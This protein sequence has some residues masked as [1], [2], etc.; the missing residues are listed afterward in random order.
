[1][2]RIESSTLAVDV[3][4]AVGGKIGQIRDKLSGREFLVAP[5][6]PYRT[7]PHGGDWLQYDTSGMDDC[8]PNIAAGPYPSEPWAATRLP[9][10]GEW[11][12]G[13][14]NVI[15]ADDN[16]IVLERMGVDLPYF[17]RKTIRFA[18]DRTLEFSYHV[19]NRG[20][21]P[22]RYMW[23]AHPLISVEGRYELKLPPGDLTFRTFPS[24]GKHHAWPQGEGGDLSH[25]WISRGKDLK[26][27]I[28]GLTAGWCE[29]RLPEHTL[30]FT[31]DV[32]MTPVVGVWFN[33][34]GFPAEGAG[35]FRC[36]AVEPCTS[37]SD[38]LDELPASA[39]PCIPAGGCASWSLGLEIINANAECSTEA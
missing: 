9:D 14:W 23:S 15:E 24:D 11:T 28:S 20:E 36:V 37:S 4:P 13:C 5:R 26:I 6:K 16:R 33:N 38:L 22:L 39:Y 29:L 34:F 19:E 10:L 18:R 25:E 30:R 3:L 27:F 2:L 1:M 21:F 12:H 8:F 35:P 31:F 17:V 32:R 7:I